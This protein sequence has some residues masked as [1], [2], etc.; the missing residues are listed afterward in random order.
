MTT[1]PTRERIPETTASAATPTRRRLMESGTIP[2]V[3][4]R[5]SAT[6]GGVYFVGATTNTFN[7][8]H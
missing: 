3:P 7:L 5:L 6:P 4:F 2:N 1:P 8:L